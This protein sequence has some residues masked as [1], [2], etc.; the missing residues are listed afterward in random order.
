M[1]QTKWLSKVSEKVQELANV[2]KAFTLGI[3]IRPSFLE[4]ENHIIVYQLL[5]RLLPFIEVL[6]NYCH[7]KIQENLLNKQSKGKEEE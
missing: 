2:Y 6:Q 1:V 3:I 5:H 7:K 4:L